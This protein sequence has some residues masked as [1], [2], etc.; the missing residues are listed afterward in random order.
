MM[1]L[2]K[3]GTSEERLLSELTLYLVPPNLMQTIPHY[4][5]LQPTDPRR[6][7]SAECDGRS[8]LFRAYGS[9]SHKS[10]VFSEWSRVLSLSQRAAWC[11]CAP[12]V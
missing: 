7:C 6:Q 12:R 5:T 8:G 4:S 1:M 2:M 9:T 3:M 11:V 10:A